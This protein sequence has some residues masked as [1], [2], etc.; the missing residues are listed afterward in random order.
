VLQLPQISKNVVLQHYFSL[1]TQV[2]NNCY[3]A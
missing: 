3:F 2:E 1:F